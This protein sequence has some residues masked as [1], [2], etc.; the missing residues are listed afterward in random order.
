VPTWELPTW[1]P[2]FVNGGHECIIAAV[3][4]DGDQALS[5]PLDGNNYPPTI[6]Q[7]N[8]G[9]VQIGAPMKGRFHYTFEVCNPARVERSFTVAAE[10]VR[11]AVA[12][13]ILKSLSREAWPE[14]RFAN[15]EHLGF[16]R[17]SSPAPSEFDAAHPVL[18]EVKLAP[19]SCTGFNLAG[20]LREGMSLIH[21]TQRFEEHVVGGLSVLVLAEDRAR[22]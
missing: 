7:R 18:E 1:A 21:V 15:P 6:A 11:P 14:E 2:S 12:A 13:R 17:T 8:L 4:E 22:T 9:V 16:A 19:L 3:V 20:T 10:A 5:G